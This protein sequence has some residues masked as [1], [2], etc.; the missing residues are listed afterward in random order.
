MA[1]IKGYFSKIKKSKSFTPLLA[2]IFLLIFDFFYIDN[3]FEITIK[4]G[5]LFGYLIDILNRGAP[6]MLIA[7]G[8]TLVIAT[9]GIDLSVGAVVAISGAISA[10]LIGGEM[11]ITQ[12]GEI[13]YETVTTVPIAIFAALFV[14]ILFGMWNGFLVSRL[15]IPAIV[16]TL[17][18]MVAGRGVAQLITSGQIITIYYEPFFFIGQ[19]YL[20]GIPFSIFIVLTVLLV[21][22]LLMR[23]TALGLFIESIGSND[24]A[25]RYLGI[26]E[27]QIKFIVY[28]FSAFC[29]AVA[30]L[31]ITSNI[32]AAD[33]NNAGLWM[34]LDAI[35]S[36][37]IGG[38]SL[39]GGKFSIFSSVLGALVVQTLTTTV[40][41]AGITPEINLVIK[42]FVV[43][44]IIIIQSEVF[45]EKVS[46]LMQRG[47]TV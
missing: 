34:E 1:L 37:V 8:M 12:A 39:Q 25:S 6:L 5:R 20:M 3:F 42:G 40:Y 28:V 38:N 9:A 21:V 17:I 2:L 41:A 16:A 14:S 19:G 18:L 45:R 13:V 22:W 4:N 32:K 46:A 27:K 26:K 44:L 47:E 33:A 23:K 36:V 31:V 43:L 11:V 7:I 30:G 10:S 15:K 29:A 35:L 24:K